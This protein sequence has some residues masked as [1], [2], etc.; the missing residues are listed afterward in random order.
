MT[1]DELIKW[2]AQGY[3]EVEQKPV[4]WYR[5]GFP[6]KVSVGGVESLKY[7]G[8]AHTLLQK[9]W[10]NPS[11]LRRLERLGFIRTRDGGRWHVTFIQPIDSEAHAYFPAAVPEKDREPRSTMEAVQAFVK[12]DKEYDVLEIVDALVQQGYEPDLIAQKI[13]KLVSENSLKRLPN[14]RI[15]DDSSPF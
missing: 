14:G 10:G 13:E 5:E 15:I 7:Y 6:Q 12:M 3:E 11:E 1:D 4:E 8:V 2:V 9:H